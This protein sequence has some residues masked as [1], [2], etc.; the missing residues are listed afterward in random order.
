MRAG[1]A[2]QAQLT[3][4]VRRLGF[5]LLNARFVGKA[6]LEIT[7]GAHPAL[8]G[9][10]R[11]DDPEVRAIQEALI[12]MGYLARGE[13]D[14]T[15]GNKTDRALKAFKKDG[16][17]LGPGVRNDPGL[18]AVQEALIDMGF[19]AS[20]E[21]DGTWGKVTEKAVVRFQSYAGRFFPDIGVGETYA[22][23]DSA[24]LLALDALAPPPGVRRPVADR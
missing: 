13:A 12:N 19:L 17:R 3:G 21:A 9:A 10:R 2:S 18:K 7:V 24:T 23:L 15:N 5:R 16:R 8:L 6:S 14:G 1:A 4:H 22:R 20:G 11:R